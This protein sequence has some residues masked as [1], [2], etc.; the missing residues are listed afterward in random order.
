MK[1][2]L[3]INILL[4]SLKKSSKHHPI[5]DGLLQQFYHLVITNEILSEYIEKIEEKTNQ[6]ISNNVGDLLIRLQNVEKN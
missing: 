1:V 3:D 2:V 5:F 4:I 6:D